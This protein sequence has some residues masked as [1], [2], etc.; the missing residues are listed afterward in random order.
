MGK[1]YFTGTVVKGYQ[2]NMVIG[3]EVCIDG[4]KKG[5]VFEYNPETGDIKIE[6]EKN[7]YDSILEKMNKQP[8]GISSRTC[9]YNLCSG[10]PAIEYEKAIIDQLSDEEREKL[11]SN[12]HK[13]CGCKNPQC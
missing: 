4:E 6:V 12:Y 7:V 11:F 8:I 13:D 5:V 2:A 1:N 9:V 10:H 3:K